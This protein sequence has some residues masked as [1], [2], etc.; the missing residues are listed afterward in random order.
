[1]RVAVEPARPGEMRAL[2]EG[3]A[4]LN[5][6]DP[7][8]EISLQDSGEHIIGAAGAHG[9]SCPPLLGG[10]CMLLFMLCSPRPLE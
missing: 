10:G 9:S 5:R 7:F 8:V 1:M 2:E 4:L 6:A 3:L